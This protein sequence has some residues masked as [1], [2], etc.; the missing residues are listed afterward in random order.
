[1]TAGV[2]TLTDEQVAEVRRRLADPQAA[3][4]LEDVRKTFGIGASR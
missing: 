3:V 1:M 2:F 4:P